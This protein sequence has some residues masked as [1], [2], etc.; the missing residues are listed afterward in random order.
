[1]KL[2]RFDD[3]RIGVVRGDAVFDVT[4]AAQRIIAQNRQGMA[5]DPLVACLAA[6]REH[7]AGDLDG[8]ARLPLARISLLAPVAA[9]GKI[10]A[11][12]VNY[13]AHIAEMLASNVS[14]GHNI[15]DIDRA[16]L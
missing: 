3:D 15:P 1:M 10:V 16:G 12:P 6:L 8:H 14:P 9:P 2:C 11:A 5:G 4:A 13:R 7:L